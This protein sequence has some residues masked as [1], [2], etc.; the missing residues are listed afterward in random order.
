MTMTFL[1]DALRDCTR[2]YNGWDTMSKTARLVIVVLFIGGALAFYLGHRRDANAPV[3]I[4]QSAPD[5]NIPRLDQ[6]SLAL[7]NYHKQVVVLNFWATWCPPCVEETPS[8]EKFAAQTKPLGVTVIG[9]SVD[10]DTAALEKFVNDYHLSYPVARDPQAALA[11]RYGTF[12]FPETYIIDRDGRVAEKIIG[13]I[14]WQDPRIVSF[15]KSLTAGGA[16]RAG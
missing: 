15:V 3:Q 4:G 5:F 14:D 6:G 12:K 8:L 11:A 7:S 16:R 10:D 13:P 9:V 2:Y 1:E